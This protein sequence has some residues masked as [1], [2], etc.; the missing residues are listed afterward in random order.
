MFNSGAEPPPPPPKKKMRKT[1]PRTT[2]E[3]SP[4][5]NIAHFYPPPGEVGAG[6]YGVASQVCPSVRVSFPK[7]I[8]ET[9]IA[10]LH[11]LGG[12]DVPFGV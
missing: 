7:Q 6:G 10:H 1:V 2:F 3:I 12:V 8:S 4:T 11:P 9:L 5:R